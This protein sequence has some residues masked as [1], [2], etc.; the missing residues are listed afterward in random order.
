[1]WAIIF[2]FKKIQEERQLE[3]DSEI[4]LGHVKFRVPPSHLSD[5][6]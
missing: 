3:E 2:I 1:M 4:I 6:I 5:D